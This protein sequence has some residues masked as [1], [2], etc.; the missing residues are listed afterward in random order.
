MR[1]LRSCRGFHTIAARVVFDDSAPWLRRCA[2]TGVVIGINA[3]VEEAETE[4]VV[5]GKRTAVQWTRNA[6]VVVDE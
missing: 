2:A 3:A 1:A 4:M 6:N 5:H